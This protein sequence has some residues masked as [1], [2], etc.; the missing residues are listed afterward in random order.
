MAVLQQHTALDIQ[1][2][3]APLNESGE[4]VLSLRGPDKSVQELSR[5]LQNAKKVAVLFFA[6]IDSDFLK[7]ALQNIISEPFAFPPNTALSDRILRQIADQTGVFI[8]RHPDSTVCI[9]QSSDMR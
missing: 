4:T 8:E 5:A 3:I 9:A 2:S 7:V 6:Q 1:Y